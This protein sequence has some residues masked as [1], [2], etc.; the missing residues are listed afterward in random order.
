[1]AEAGHFSR[2]NAVSEALLHP[3]KAYIYAEP[4]YCLRI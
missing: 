4:H 1:M 2:Y 3:V